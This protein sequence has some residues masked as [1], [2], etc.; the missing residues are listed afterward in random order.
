MKTSPIDID[1]ALISPRSIA[2]LQLGKLGDTI[3]TTPLFNALKRLY[4]EAKL[5]VIGAPDA[6][7]LARTNR[8]VDGIIEAPRGFRQ[9]PTLAGRLRTARFDLY[10]DIKDHRSTTSKL[11]A[12][13][14]HATAIICHPLNAP[15]NA[16]TLALPTADAP[17][18]YVD[19]ALAPLKALAPERRFPRRP[20]IDI[21][22]EAYRAV[23]GQLNPGANGEIAIN[24]SAGDQSRYWEPAKWR[25]L[26]G[27]L[28]RR[29]SVAL[30][31]APADRALADE[32][33][34]MRLEARSVRTQSI[35]EAA[36]VVERSIAVISP[37]TSIVHLA[38]AFDKPC[39]GLYPSSPDNARAFAP[40]SARSTMVMAPEAGT[41]QGIT[42]GQVIDAFE[43]IMR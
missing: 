22:V 10:I 3:L 25:Q 6:M 40:L 15:H 20:T 42:V 30:L 11:V 24:I 14:V 29:Y 12:E 37:D 38:S 34:T 28:A 17:G 36:A 16:A 18:H 8:S 39:V 21:P 9:I 33:C 23:D 2:V 19:G 27:E 7:P 35:L 13:L 31:S 43:E 26:I 5:T 32:I 4:P 1:P 41:F